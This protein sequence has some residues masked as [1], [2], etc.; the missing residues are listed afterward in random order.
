MR[1]C[2]SQI[3]EIREMNSGASDIASQPIGAVK[4]LAVFEIA[5]Q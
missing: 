4:T 2:R 5:R 1:H 3:Q